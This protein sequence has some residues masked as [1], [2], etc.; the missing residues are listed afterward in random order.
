MESTE[1]DERQRLPFFRIGHGENYAREIL[2]QYVTLRVKEHNKSNHV[3]WSVTINNH[4]W[5][6][7]LLQ[8]RLRTRAICG[9][10]Y[11]AHTTVLQKQVS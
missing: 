1:K 5:Y 10:V 6:N 4:C 11:N 9:L 3:L 7:L 8:K 2:V